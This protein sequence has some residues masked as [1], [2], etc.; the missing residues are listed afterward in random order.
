M[1]ERISCNFLAFHFSQSTDMT[2]AFVK[3]FCLS[4]ALNDQTNRCFSVVCMIADRFLQIVENVNVKKKIC[5]MQGM[6]ERLF[7]ET[8]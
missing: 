7:K 5:E 8:S 6:L 1:K 2:T 4:S 3:S